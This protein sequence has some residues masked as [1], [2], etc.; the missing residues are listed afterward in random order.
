MKKILLSAGLLCLSFGAFAQL[1][2]GLKVTPNMAWHRVETT[3]DVELDADGSRAHLS[4]GIVADYF[5]S[6]NYA[7]STGLLLSTKGGKLKYPTVTLTGTSTKTSDVMVQYVEL[8]ITLKLFTNEIAP[9]A[10]VYFQVGGAAGVLVAARID[11]EKNVKANPADPNSSEEK[12]SKS[13][14]TLELSGLLGAGVEYQ[15]GQSTKVFAGLHYQHGLTNIE[16]NK[17]LGADLKDD[18]TMKNSVIGIDLGLKF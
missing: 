17:F 5:F 1:E 3:N 11:D 6:E 12:V 9:D 18:L 7:F 10:R 8:P 4:G 2:I 16:D 14:N 13:F 15:L